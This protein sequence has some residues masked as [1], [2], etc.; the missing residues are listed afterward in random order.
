MVRPAFVFVFCLV[1][2]GV[3]LMLQGC[4]GVSQID[5]ANAGRTRTYEP[6]LPNFDMEA[7]ATQREGVPGIDL[8]LSI[9]HISLVFL[10]TGD[11]Y[12]AQYEAIIRLLD[13]KS[14]KL[15]REQAFVDTVRVADYA[16]TQLF[17]P[18]VQMRRVEAAPGQ[19][20][21]EV[22]VVDR[23]SEK[24]AERRQAVAVIGSDRATPFLSR[25]HLEGRRNDGPFEPVVSLYVPADIDSLRAD[26][27][28]YNLHETDSA[29]VRMRL[30]RFESDTST[31][32]SPYWLGP[33][34][35]SLTYRGV[36][37]DRADTIQVTRRPL[38]GIDESIAV[39]FILPPLLEGIYRVEMQVRM[40]PVGGEPR[41][42][43][44]ERDFSVTPAGFPQITTLDQMIQALI[45]IAYE[46]EVKLILEA[47]TPDEKKRRFDA[48][49]GS[50]VENREVAANLIK[51]YY[52]RIEEANLLF[53]S[54]KEGWKTDRGMVYIMMG[55]P[56]YVENTVE[57]ETWRYSYGDYN[58]LNTFVF[59]RNQLY[60]S[61]ETFESYLLQRH[62][63]Y[64]QVWLRAL[65][66]WRKGQML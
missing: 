41:V 63:Y 27:E 23:R 64:E 65:E 25:I 32:L 36:Q 2:F 26:V 15:V 47:E 8:Y 46:R 48:F 10:Y 4:S 45:Y 61:N 59:E 43:E 38:E 6:G 54:H 22:T 57:T 3:S 17:L 7:I 30:L 62:P 40:H 16:A 29:E 21:V 44:Q 42:L 33:S 18:L 55:A 9:P 19:Y 11:E 37:Y 31:A 49:W 24:E 20:I 50:L 13:R 58:P 5:T 56:L 53:T 12:I 1:A 52:S 51:L 39:S 66:R 60:D 14:K 34:F 28:L 35:G